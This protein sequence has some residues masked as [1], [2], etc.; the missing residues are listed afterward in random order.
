MVQLKLGIYE[1][2]II[3]HLLDENQDLGLLKTKYFPQYLFIKKF[4]KEVNEK[5]AETK[6]WKNPEEFF[7]KYNK[8]I[9]NL[10]LIDLNLSTQLLKIHIQRGLSFAE[11]YLKI[12]KPALEN[13][14]II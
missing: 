14:E 11:A 3:V 13:E 8:D 12:F 9:A 5:M 10:H 6:K 1:K 2:V 4:A 7:E